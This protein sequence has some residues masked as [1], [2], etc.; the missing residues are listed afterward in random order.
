MCQCR[1]GK[2]VRG[3]SPDRQLEIGA[4]HSYSIGPVERFNRVITDRKYAPAI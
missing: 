4:V 3:D 2:R 1:A